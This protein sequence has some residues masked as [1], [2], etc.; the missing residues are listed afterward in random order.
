MSKKMLLAATAITAAVMGTAHADTTSTRYLVCTPILG[1]NGTDPIVEVG[2]TMEITQRPNGNTSQIHWIVV[3]RSRHGA[4]YVREEQYGDLRW[5][6]PNF[7][8]PLWQ[9]TGHLKGNYPVFMTG[10]VADHGRGYITYTEYL[11]NWDHPWEGTRPNTR[12]IC[13]DVAEVVDAEGSSPARQEPRPEAATKTTV[14]EDLHIRQNPS[15]NS[16]DVLGGNT[17]PPGTIFNF[18]DLTV[19]RKAHNGYMWCPVFWP[20]NGYKIRGWV[21]AY[22]LR[23][24]NGQRL[25][26]FLQPGS[27]QCADVDVQVPNHEEEA[28]ATQPYEPASPPTMRDAPSWLK[29]PRNTPRH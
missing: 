22:F 13:R 20:I 27:E 18:T 25:A 1:D 5:V 19:C 16:V 17:I 14:I 28:Q 9:W 4:A 3:H 12:S 11:A 29:T 21:S 15:A 24:E 7:S 8:R 23:L 2:V 26:C 10:E 6:Q